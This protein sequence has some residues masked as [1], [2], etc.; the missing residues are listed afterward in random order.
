MSFEIKVDLKKTIGAFYDLAKPGKES[1]ANISD[2][3]TL[4]SFKGFLE[5]CSKN[6]AHDNIDMSKVAALLLE[7]E[8]NDNVPEEY[9]DL[10]ANFSEL[11]KINKKLD[12]SERRDFVFFAYDCIRELEKLENKVLCEYESTDGIFACASQDDDI[13]CIVVVNNTNETVFAD[14]LIGGLPGRSASIDY[15]YADEYNQLSIACNTDTKL[16]ETKI[17][18]P[19]PEY[20]LHLFKIR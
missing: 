6:G 16:S 10:S 14:I 18:I 4:C 11:V 17:M 13:S 19:M 12:V 8:I 1:D 15:Y 3:N 5:V 9:T 7:M 2:V 20:S